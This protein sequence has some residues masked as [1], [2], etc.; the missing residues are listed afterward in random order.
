MTIQVDPDGTVE[1]SGQLH[2]DIVQNNS[3]YVISTTIVNLI[4]SH[5]KHMGKCWF[6]ESE[7][8]P[9]ISWS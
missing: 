8:H 4:N 6:I 5:I 3:K 9:H 2:K 1:W 7:S